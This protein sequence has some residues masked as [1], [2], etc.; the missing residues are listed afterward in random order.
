MLQFCN[1]YSK[2]V[3][4]AYIFYEPDCAEGPIN[5]PWQSLG[6]FI[7]NPGQCAIVYAND[8]HD[9]NNRY[10]YFYADSPDGTVWSGD[11]VI[12]TPNVA[13]DRCIGD[14]LPSAEDPHPRGFR[15]LDVG[16]YD[17]FTVNLLGP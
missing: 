12:M 2:L 6:W 15:L 14:P 4:V 17:D 5:L 10:W 7:I 8:L 13:F 3:S 9:V 1:H 16:D 11:V